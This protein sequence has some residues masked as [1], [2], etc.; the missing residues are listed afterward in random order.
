MSNNICPS[1]RKMKGLCHLSIVW[2]CVP[3]STSPSGMNHDRGFGGATVCTS[4]TTD[5]MPSFVSW[6]RKRAG[7]SISTPE[8]QYPQAMSAQWVCVLVR[9]CGNR[10]KCSPKLPFS[11]NPAS[12]SSLSAIVCTMSNSSRGVS[13]CTAIL[14]QHGDAPSGRTTTWRLIVGLDTGSE[15]PVRRLLRCTTNGQ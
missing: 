13:T 12:A 2:L 9:G 5:F 14:G 7:S 3:F 6:G 8:S 4:R 1:M 11:S 10:R 15:L